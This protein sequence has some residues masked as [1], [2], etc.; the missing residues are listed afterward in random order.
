MA[1]R[2]NGSSVRSTSQD[3]TR[4]ESNHHTGRLCWIVGPMGASV[5]KRE[6]ENANTVAGGKSKMEQYKDKSREYIKAVL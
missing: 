5:G 6:E 1:K 3:W 4:E 2:V